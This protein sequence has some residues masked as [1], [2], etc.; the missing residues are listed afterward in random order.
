MSIEEMRDIVRGLGRGD[1][2]DRLLAVGPGY[3]EMSQ[4]LRPIKCFYAV[5]VAPIPGDESVPPV[6]HSL[7]MPSWCNEWWEFVYD[8]FLAKT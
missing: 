1:M 8:S 4:P 7:G 2:A 5:K 6:T 3:I